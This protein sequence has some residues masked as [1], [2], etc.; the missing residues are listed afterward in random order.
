MNV[1]GNLLLLRHSTQ[2]SQ[3]VLGES[4]GRRPK[5]AFQGLAGRDTIPD[6]LASA[7]RGGT[8]RQDL[9]WPCQFIEKAEI[10]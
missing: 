3:G 5:V 1:I 4:P 9:P 7:G 10:A 6:S 8:L 2:A